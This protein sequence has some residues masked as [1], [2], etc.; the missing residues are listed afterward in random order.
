MSD[1]PPRHATGL[2]LRFVAM[3]VLLVT[4]IMVTDG[5]IQYANARSM[6]SGL[7][8]S[9]I[10]A[11]AARLGDSLGS[12]LW[13]FNKDQATAILTAEAGQDTIVAIDVRMGSDKGPFAGVAKTAGTIGSLAD[14]SSLPR[15]LVARKFDVPWQ[16]KNIAQGT[17]W[18]SLDALKRTLGRQLLETM[19]RMVLADLVL[20]GLIAFVLSRLV[21]RP[22]RSLTRLA[23]KLA[24]GD[25]AVSIN[26]RLLA[27]RDEFGEFAE[28]FHRMMGHNLDVIHRVKEAATTLSRSADE[29]KDSS[30]QMARGAAEQAASAEEVSSSLEEMSASIR[31]IA[32]NAGGTERIA[33]KAAED[34]ESGSESVIRTVSAM[35]EISSRIMIIE[36]IA[37]NTNLLALNA[38]IEAARAGESG[39]GFAVVAA[40]VRKLAERSQK[41]AN[42]ISDLSSK[43]M[44]IAE[45]AGKI[46]AQIAPDIKRTADLVQEITVAS[47]EQSVGADQIMKA[48]GTLDTVIQDNAASAEEIAGITRSIADQARSMEEAI[49][50]FRTE[51]KSE[52]AAE[53]PAAKALVAKAPATGA[54]RDRAIVPIRG[55]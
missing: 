21:V 14:E 6:Y 35:K 22:L 15:G 11:M 19:V 30:D 32:D 24:E 29:L 23:G 16:G 40:E 27:R 34:T 49:A 9:N 50:F 36:E 28:A 38:A 48:I 2:S 31:Q 43:S 45:R 25:L 1:A 20:V 4:L 42:E 44:G 54:S 51:A 55:A 18:Y 41:A 7:V 33:V 3:V 12:P 10:D 47:G 13:N 5:L 53:T 52:S 39:K 37:R 26:P 8:N 17:I 46:L